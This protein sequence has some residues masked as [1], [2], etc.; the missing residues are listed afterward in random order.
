MGG[1]S[2]Q[3]KLSVI[4]PVYNAEDTLRDTLEDL[5]SSD[6]DDFEVILVDDA[7]TDRSLQI[8][9]NFDCRFRVQDENRGPS[10]AR[11]RGAREANGEI[12]FFTDSDVTVLP[13]TIGKI[14][15]TLEKNPDF[16]ALIG[17]YTIDTPCQDFFSTFKNLV[18]HYT[19]QNSMDIAIT[20]WAGCGAIKRDAFHAVNGF[21]E[22][23]KR[24]SIEDIELG[25]R[26]TRAGHKILLVKDVLVTHNKKYDFTGL[27]KSD[28]YNR[29]IPWTALMLKE[30]MMRSDLNTTRS[31]AIGLVSSYMTTIGL[32]LSPLYPG[33][34]LL[35]LAFFT[36]FLISNKHFYAYAYRF[37][38]IGFML[39]S[40]AM[41]FIFYLYSGVGF[42]LGVASYLRG[43][44]R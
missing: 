6:Y 23:Y 10:A 20:F 11:N 32:V 9:R 8:A 24:A 1:K 15:R 39:Q 34:L 42:V 29:A 35:S 5:F 37:K 25:Y 31:N 26:L 12:L 3:P 16:S 27:V 22:Y 4:I 17:S 33:F 38:G 43:A 21:D 30:R 41:N 36:T 14:V 40:I 2:K 18:H 28:V 19:H 13:D 44:Q 7:S